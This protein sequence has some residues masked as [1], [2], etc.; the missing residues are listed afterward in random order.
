MTATQ[1][2]NSLGQWHLSAAQRVTPQTKTTHH[3]YSL[4]FQFQDVLKNALLCRWDLLP[5]TNKQVE[6]ETKFQTTKQRRVG[7]Q[8]S[9]IRN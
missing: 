3:A 2:K 1:N 4:S 9:V 8:R 7:L 6:Y 5:L